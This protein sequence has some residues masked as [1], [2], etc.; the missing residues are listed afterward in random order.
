MIT[1]RQKA[2]LAIPLLVVGFFSIPAYGQQLHRQRER[3]ISVDDVP[4]TSFSCVNR[5]PGYYAD[6]ETDC[7]VY[8]MCTDGGTQFSYKCPNTTLFQQ[9]MLICAHWYQVNCSR[10]EQHYSANLLIGQRDKPFVEE[11]YIRPDFSNGKGIGT[12]KNPDDLQSLHSGNGGVVTNNFFQNTRT[13]SSQQYSGVHNSPTRNQFTPP[14]TAGHTNPKSYYH[15][16]NQH[17]HS[18]VPSS[19]TK[20][21]QTYQT[22]NRFVSV[23]TPRIHQ[24]QQT[25]TTFVPAVT[26]KVFQPFQTKSTNFVPSLKHSSTTPVPQQNQYKINYSATAS[27]F[28]QKLNLT[29]VNQNGSYN[30]FIKRFNPNFNSN[31]SNDD[32]SLKQYTFLKRFTPESS[33]TTNANG[34]EEN[35]NVAPFVNS[36]VFSDVNLIVDNLEP[37]VE[38]PSL[39]L[40]APLEDADQM[41]SN[42][43]ELQF[44]DPRQ[45]FFIP[46]SDSQIIP[47]ETATPITINIP[48]HV[49]Q[50]FHPMLFLNSV[51]ETCVRCHPAFIMNKTSC[52]PCVVIR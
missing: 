24:T 49:E 30:N 33:Q 18:F 23:T 39:N 44:Q 38:G 40:E 15:I 52:T 17:F 41:E 12:L 46:D 34:N 14:Q 28:E 21:P 1:W 16:S 9:R 31:N 7:Q 36:N 32:Y 51:S 3:V 19:T 35:Q 6:V 29:A 47:A 43:L 8:H 11:T 13:V 25:R 48:R 4:V 20:A 45:V 27:S 5:T 50:Q 10:S 22:Q 37:P 2:L 42:V 26:P